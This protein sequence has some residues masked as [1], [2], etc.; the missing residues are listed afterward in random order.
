MPIILLITI[1]LSKCIPSLIL[2][3]NLTKKER[4]ILGIG[5]CVQFSTGMAILTQLFNLNIISSATYSSLMAT[6][7]LITIV[8]PLIF[9]QLV[10][11]V[12]IQK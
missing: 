7:S 4:L 5:L 10:S 8:I 3:K 11:K 2:F 6:I 12:D 1:I 9:S